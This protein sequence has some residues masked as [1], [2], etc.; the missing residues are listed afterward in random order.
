MDP[1]SIATGAA[2]L[3]KTA[4]SLVKALH[5]G[6]EAVKSVDANLGV[7]AGE[8]SAL[9]EALHLVDC[10]FQDPRLSELDTQDEKY[11]S[12]VL[13][14]LRKILTDCEDTLVKLDAIINEASKGFR[15]T[16]L[17]RTVTAIKL[18]FKSANIVLVRQQIQTYSTAMQMTLSMLNISLVLH[19]NQ[20]SISQKSKLG[21]EIESLEDIGRDLQTKLES[22]ASPLNQE[23]R[24]KLHNLNK[25]LQVSQ[26]VL[27]SASTYL[28][29]INGSVLGDMRNIN[30]GSVLGLDP[31]QI[32]AI[33]S[34][35]RPIAG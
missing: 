9:A 13:K 6:I 31:G 18:N 4:Y 27:S 26:S 21:E 11:T 3:S 29:S 20:P 10:A 25:H 17:R 34:W 2:A 28:G 22:S 15:K 32:S 16:L 12:T 1:L 7:F 30:E 8:V 35:R 24:A 19:Q 14:S 5:S 33:D 23:S